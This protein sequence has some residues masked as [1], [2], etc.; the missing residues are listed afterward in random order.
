MGGHIVLV[1]Q[2]S[3][4]HEQLI[5]NLATDGTC[6][7]C[8]RSVEEAVAYLREPA[9]PASVVVFNVTMR[10]Q[11]DYAAVIALG[12]ARPELQML[13]AAQERGPMLDLLSSGNRAVW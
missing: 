13:L 5:Q 8:F 9:C 2:N 4:L 11:S 12:V 3:Q 7:L 1:V 10:R 6:A